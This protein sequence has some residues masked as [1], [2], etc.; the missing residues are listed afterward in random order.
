M[1]P[2]NQL[3]TRLPDLESSREQGIACFTKCKS[4]YCSLLLLNERINESHHRKRPADAGGGGGAQSKEK[5]DNE[6]NKSEPETHCLKR[7]QGYLNL[8]LVQDMP[9]RF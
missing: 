7:R 3:F 9:V 8:F 6:N 1:S 5:Q 2:V 4:R